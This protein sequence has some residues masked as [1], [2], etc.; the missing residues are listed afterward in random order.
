[1]RGRRLPVN[2]RGGC[3]CT[4]VRLVESQSKP[5]SA[6]S[7]MLFA[8]D[9]DYVRVRGKPRSEPQFGF[10]LLRIRIERSKE[11]HLNLSVAELRNDG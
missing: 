2:E 1:V 11:G 5:T 8:E 3:P 9:C 10:Y 7:R 6:A 4:G